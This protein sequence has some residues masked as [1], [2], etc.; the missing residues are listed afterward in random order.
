MSFLIDQ[1]FFFNQLLII[2]NMTRINSTLIETLV[3]I[4]ISK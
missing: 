1:I 3:L 2:D 4:E